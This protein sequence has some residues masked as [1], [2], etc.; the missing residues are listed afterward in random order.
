MVYS[1]YLHGAGAYGRNNWITNFAQ[2]RL[3]EVSEETGGYAY[4]LG[5]TDPVTI[6]PFLKDF[7]SRLDNQYRVTIET[8]SEKGVQ[9]VKLRGV[10][11]GLKIEGPTRI[12][13]R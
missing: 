3:I 13:V 11:G 2:S 10:L 7:Q 1:I 8:P 5:F 4:S 6:A 12:F 9:P